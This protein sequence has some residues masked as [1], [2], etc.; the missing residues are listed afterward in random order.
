MSDIRWTYDKLNYVKK[1]S[2]ATH[3]KLFEEIVAL[4]ETFEMRYETLFKQE[5]NSKLC[6]LF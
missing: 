3:E 1:S 2:S 4:S 6:Q 5:A